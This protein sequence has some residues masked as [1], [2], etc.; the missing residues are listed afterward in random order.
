MSHA[1]GVMCP[2]CGAVT[3]PDACPEG[4]PDGHGF[5]YALCDDRH[6][7]ATPTTEETR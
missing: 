4:C 2:L 5:T 7:P 3:Q 6:L 1:L